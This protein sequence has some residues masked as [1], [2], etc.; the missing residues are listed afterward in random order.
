MCE[1]IVLS[2]D[3]LQTTMSIEI[4]STRHQTGDT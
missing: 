4:I 3:F 1:S 2:S